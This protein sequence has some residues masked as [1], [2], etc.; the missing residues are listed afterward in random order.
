MGKLG[1]KLIDMAP[2]H[3]IVQMVPQSDDTNI[4]GLVHGGA[5]FSLMDEAF[6]VSSNSDGRVAV[7]LDVNVIFHNPAKKGRKLKAES[8]E[9]HSSQKIAAYEIRVTDEDD[10]LIATCHAIAYR[11]KEKLPFLSDKP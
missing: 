8:N 6:M 7:A 11:K 4:F 5:I 2:G 1:F 9:I 10:V 3:A